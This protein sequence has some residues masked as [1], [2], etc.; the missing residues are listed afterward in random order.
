VLVQAF[1]AESAVE[2]QNIGGSWPDIALQQASNLNQPTTA[3]PTPTTQ[4]Q[5]PFGSTTSSLFPAATPFNQVGFFYDPHEKNPM[6][7]QWNFGV[8]RLFGQTTTV[9][10]NYVGSVSTRLSVGS[11]YNTALTPGPGDPQSRALHTYI[12]PTFYSRSVGTSNY[13]AL[14]LSLDKR[15]SNGLAYQVAYT[16]SKSMDV[17]GIVDFQP[18]R[19]LFRRPVQDQFTGHNRLQLLVDG[20]KAHLGS[21]S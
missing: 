19:N 9:T 14:Q 7:N 8:E 15:Y 2:S 20:K 13:N 6:S 18:C 21:Q 5:D 17:G 10:A 12:A 11:Y 1:L 16:W 3:L 4:A